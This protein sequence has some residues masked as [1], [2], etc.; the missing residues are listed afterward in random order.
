M[1]QNTEK[2]FLEHIED[3]RWLIIKSALALTIS[4]LITCIEIRDI[5]AL[6]KRPL[7]LALKAKGM[8]AE[9]FL[10]TLDVTD[11]INMVLG[12]GLFAGLILALPFIFYFI[13]SYLL[14]A[15]TPKE[16]KLLLPSFFS[17]GILFIGGAVFCYF[18]VL[19]QAVS[20]FLEFNDWLGLRPTWP[21]QNYLEFTLQMLIGFGISF[22][23]PLVIMLLVKLELISRRFLVNY[24]RHAIVVI[25]VAAA[26]IT[27]T[28]DPYNLFM[29]FF[30]M[31][32]LYEISILGA[33]W[34]ER[35]RSKNIN[36]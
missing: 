19:Q 8:T 16:K 31:Y 35:G 15:L 13:G 27:P 10:I 18:F 22:E 34:I 4:T 5:M 28:S 3:L 33:W 12:V 23:L 9:Q 24:R 14:P 36:V 32:F 7:D 17:G 20:F 29:M 26:C 11:P 25:L 6:L 1:N 21:L 30:P 2:S